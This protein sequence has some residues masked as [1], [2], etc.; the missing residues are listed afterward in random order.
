[1]TP[2][3]TYTK[4]TRTISV[5]TMVPAFEV[6]DQTYQRQTIFWTAAGVYWG[7]VGSY[8]S[9]TSVVL[10]PDGNLPTV[11]SSILGLTV[12]DTGE[13]H[14]FQSYKDQVS[15]L[16]KDD[17][18]KITT[19][20][21][22]DLEKILARAF[23]VYN[24]DKPWLV[25]KK[26]PGNG[27]RDFSLASEFGGLYVPGYSYFEKIEY[28]LNQT[29][30]NLLES[31][32]YEIYDDGTAIDGSNLVLRLNGLA[33][34]VTEYLV[35]TFRAE[36]DFPPA[37]VA[38]FPDTDETFYAVTTLAAS[39]ACSILAAAY[40]TS[41]DSTIS[42]DVVNYNE[43]TRKYRDLARDYREQYNLAVFGS[44]ETDRPLSGA[45]LD[46]DQDLNASDRGQRLFHG[47]RSR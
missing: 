29:P 35:A 12:L 32:E 43:K 21:G 37:G 41:K 18:P 31:E 27:T 16:I 40:A 26:V 14:T 3:A 42:A 23:S 1:L 36:R 38:N 44:A 20:S 17:V 4:A 6:A 22:G 34:G 13:E 10:L 47:G 9:A 46:V 5:A 25:A 45:Y 39:M 11:D 24:T 8:V 30:S 7:R 28:P 33:P 2:P 19:T 15:S